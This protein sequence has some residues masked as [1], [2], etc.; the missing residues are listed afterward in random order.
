MSNEKAALVEIPQD[1]LV[2]AKRQGNIPDYQMK[3]V[4][5]SPAEPCLFLFP[6][7]P[8]VQLFQ[9]DDS[10]FTISKMSV[11]TSVPICPDD[12]NNKEQQSPKVSQT[13]HCQGQE[14]DDLVSCDLSPDYTCYFKFPSNCFVTL[15]NREM[16]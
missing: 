3:Y 12:A 15:R 2:Y 13:N 4:S 16:T 9:Q 5:V 7:H 1:A 10:I 6:C 14:F 8:K 11:N